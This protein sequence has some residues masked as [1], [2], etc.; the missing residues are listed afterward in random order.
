MYGLV[1]QMS[2]VIIPKGERVV[3]NMQFYADTVTGVALSAVMCDLYATCLL[4]ACF[5][6]THRY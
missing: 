2:M 4:A 6:V 5:G 3:V 1:I